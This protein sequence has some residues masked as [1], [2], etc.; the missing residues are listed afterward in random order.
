MEQNLANDMTSLK[1]TFECKYLRK[2]SAGGNCT[3]MGNTEEKVY[4][5]KVVI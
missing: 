3:N 5:K 4:K 2:L 1:K